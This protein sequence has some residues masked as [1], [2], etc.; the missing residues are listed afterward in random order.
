MATQYPASFEMGHSG[1]ERLSTNTSP[2]KDP[3]DRADSGYGSSASTPDGKLSEIEKFELEH[4]VSRQLFSRF[5]K[6]KLRPFDQEISQAVQNRFSD[7]TEL[8]GPSLYTFLVKKRVRYNAISIKLKVLGKDERSARPWVVVQCDEAASKPIK[9]FFDQPE[10]KS[11]YRPGDSEP[12]LPSF[13]VVIHP[14][15]P[16]SLATSH[17]AN[18]YGNSWADVETLCGRLIKIGSP[19]EPHIATLGGVIMVETSRGKFMLQGLTAG[20][21]LT[22]EPTT[23]HGNGRESPSTYIDTAHSSCETAPTYLKPEVQKVENGLV[24]DVGHPQ[25]QED[26]ESTASSELDEEYFEIDLAVEIDKATKG[27]TSFRDST[28][29]ITTQDS[30]KQSWSKIGSIYSTSR[31]VH[32]RLEADQQSGSDQDWALVNIEPEMY[33]PN[34]LADQPSRGFYVELTELS[35][36]LDKPEGSRAVLLVSG[37]GGLK[38]G[39]LSLSPSFL[40]LGQAKSFTKTYNLVLHDVPGMITTLGFGTLY[41]LCSSYPPRAEYR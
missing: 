19:D 39:S 9:N 37:I 28:L 26:G 2:D 4:K 34:L 32:A 5:R 31:D 7:L 14:R 24:H 21:I 41:I 27:P 13:D 6:I 17:L 16:V 20:H 15:A 36:E 35:G 23:G 1:V 11:Q 38:R 33:R 8:F 3:V 40:M 30:Q 22:Q 18:V 29:D 10:V 25:E 12:H